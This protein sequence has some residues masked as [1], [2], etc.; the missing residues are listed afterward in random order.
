VNKYLKNNLTNINIK[1]ARAG[2]FNLQEKFIGGRIYTQIKLKET[3][4]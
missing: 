4:D 2:F 1:P 3:F